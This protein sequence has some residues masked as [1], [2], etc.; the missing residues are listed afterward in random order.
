MTAPVY[1]RPAM[2]LIDRAA[3]PGG[4][5]L[6]I[7]GMEAARDLPLLGRHGIRVVVNCAVNL[8]IDL[9]A[10]PILEAG[11]GR[12]RAGYGALRYYKLGM[13]DGH[14]NPAEMMLGAYLLLCGAMDQQMP[15]RPTY[16]FESG[17]NVLVNCRAGRSRSVA[18]V[19]L[20]LHRQHPGRYP[21]LDAAIAH[22]RA[23]REL[24]PDEWFETPKPM[25]IEAARRASDL[26][27]RIEGAPAD[28]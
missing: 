13:I 16:P 20:Y 5:A 10:T 8:D 14:G 4:V 19:S 23:R 26:L 17:G 9:V 18:L 15:D 27:D 12:A 28:A 24:R 3:G 2:S 1:D 22:V 6:Y 7:G 11:S 25:L 21:D